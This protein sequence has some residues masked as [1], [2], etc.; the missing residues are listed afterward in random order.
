[1]TS[2]TGSNSRAGL[3]LVEVLVAVVILA[4]GVVVVL[5]ALGT[6]S[7]AVAV[8][9]AHLQAYAI[10]VSKIAELEMARRLEPDPWERQS[11]VVWIGRDQVTW[12]AAPV[13]VAADPTLE[14]VTLTIGWRQGR[15]TYARRFSTVWRL[16]QLS[17][18][19]S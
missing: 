18:D 16:P 10:A 5:P 13:P 1:M 4:V 15:Q 12:D 7:R 17:E 3:S 14:Q 9:D 2:P 8:A 6:I 19:T 11:G